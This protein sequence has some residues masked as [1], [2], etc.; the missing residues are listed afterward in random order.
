MSTTL[1]ETTLR[2]L[3]AAGALRRVCAAGQVGGFAVAVFCG[4]AATETYLASTRGEVR[5]FPNLTT[6]AAHLRRLGIEQFEVNTAGYEPARVRK[7]R[8]DRARALRRTRTTP[9]QPRLF[10]GTS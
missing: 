7:A 4:T 6:L 5:V 10:E 9:T 8:P 3:A 2:E 1:R